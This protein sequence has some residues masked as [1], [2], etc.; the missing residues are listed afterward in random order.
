MNLKVLIDT[1]ANCSVLSQK[2]Y[3]DNIEIFKKCPHLPIS[4]KIIIS[5]IK[6]KTVALR[7]QIMCQVKIGNF[8]DYM[9]FI[10]VP[11][12][13]KE[14]IIGF[15]IIKNLGLIIDSQIDKIYSNICDINVTYAL[16]SSEDY[17]SCRYYVEEILEINNNIIFEEFSEYDIKIKEI[18][19]KV[20]ECVELSAS[21][22]FLLK[23][24]IYDNRK[25][26]SKKPGLIKNYE[27]ELQIIEEKP[28]YQR[29][30]PIALHKK[31]KVMEA[32]NKMLELGIISRANTEYIS[33]ITT[34]DKKDGSLRI[35]MDS[36][37]LNTIIKNDYESP[38]SC[39]DVFM[40]C[41]AKKHLS[42]LDMCSSFWQI[43]LTEN[44]KKYT[45]FSIDGKIY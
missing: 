41:K 31:Q 18:N 27:Y 39:E 3:H 13:S 4:G 24:I 19:D 32:I 7:I 10:V 37:G 5:A 6:E 15:D 2:Y 40:K 33:P 38:M 34:S 1:G 12:L 45:G 35:V 20:N 25:A 21:K 9:V 23:K 28:F 22:K 8:Q 14:C 16:D 36:R 30:Y 29:A 26:F 11:K 43:A 17:Q 44:S 42:I